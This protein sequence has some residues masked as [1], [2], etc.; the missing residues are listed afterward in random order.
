MM[1]TITVKPHKIKRNVKDDE[2][3]SKT[4]TKILNIKKSV[5]F[6]T[7]LKV[8]YNMIFMPETFITQ[9]TAKLFVVRVHQL[10][11]L[12]LRVCIETLWTFTANIRLHI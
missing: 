6:R 7:S 11:S 3:Y 4:E 8:P 5:D 10:M 9:K 1:I 2:S 12:Q